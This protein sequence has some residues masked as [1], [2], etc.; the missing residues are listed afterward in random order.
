MPLA[1]EAIDGLWIALSVF[2]VLTAI[3]LAIAVGVGTGSRAA[4]ADDA[5]DPAAAAKQFLNSCGTCHTV[6]DGAPIRQ[7]PNLKTVLGRKAGTLA[8]FPAYSDA[9]KA[10]GAG[11]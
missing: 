3:G 10:A 9:I 7:G 1:F 5:V 2:F 4:Q 6:E 8:E 11:E